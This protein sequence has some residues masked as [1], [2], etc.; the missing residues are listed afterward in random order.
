MASIGL[1]DAITTSHYA[2]KTPP[3]AQ[4]RKNNTPINSIWTTRNLEIAPT[5]RYSAFG[6]SH[7]PYRP[8]RSRL[9]ITPC[10]EDTSSNSKQEPYYT[11]TFRQHMAGRQL[12][13]EQAGGGDAGGAWMRAEAEV[14]LKTACSDPWNRSI[15][16]LV[17]KV[18]DK[19]QSNTIKHNPVDTYLNHDVNISS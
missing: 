15:N 6:D 9:H 16:R 12:L 4:N 11:H 3:A 8:P 19:Q 14:R 1:Q 7:M 5:E 17:S 10:G 18:P 2:E 13:K